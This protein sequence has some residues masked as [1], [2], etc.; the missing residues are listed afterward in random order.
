[1]PSFGRANR[2]TTANCDLCSEIV[3][4]QPVIASRSEAIPSHARHGHVGDCFAAARNDRL[5]S[6]S[7]CPI[8][9]K[10]DEARG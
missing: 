3:T 6:C 1:M 4:A 7:V 2:K 10:Y 9:D 5:S 8:L